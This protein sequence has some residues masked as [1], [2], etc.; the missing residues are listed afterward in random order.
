MYTVDVVVMIPNIVLFLL[1][2]LSLASPEAGVM[3]VRMRKFVAL[4]RWVTPAELV[5]TNKDLSGEYSISDM[6]LAPAVV[7]C[8]HHDCT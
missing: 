5:V 2:L 3:D 8:R 1:N 7:L 6:F 4:H